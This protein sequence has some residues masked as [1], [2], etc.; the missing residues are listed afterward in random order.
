VGPDLALVRYTPGGGVDLT[1]GAGGIATTNFGAQTSGGYGLARHPDGK[2]VVAGFASPDAEVGPQS[3]ADFAVARFDPD[4]QLDR[5]FHGGA[6]LTEIGVSTYDAASGVAVQPDGK[7]VIGGFTAESAGID[8]P[9]DFAVVR[10]LETLA[11]VPPPPPG[12]P[13]ASPPP[14]PPPAVKPPAVVRCVVPN[15]R[16]KT[17]VRARR[18]LTLKRCGLGRIKRAYS[19]KFKTGT[20]ISQSRRPGARLPRGTRVNVVVSRGKRRAQTR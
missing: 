17:V 16:R 8:D 2:F 1:F 6:V 12:P 20:I 9:A 19:S 4:G 3:P 5:A 11:P 18:L 10:Y 14:P 7:I 15:V 13:T